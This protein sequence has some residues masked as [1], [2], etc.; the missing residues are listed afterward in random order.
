[1]LTAE[2]GEGISAFE[3]LFGILI[4]HPKVTVNDLVLHSGLRIPWQSAQSGH[5]V[6]LPTL[7]DGWQSWS[8]N[9]SGS[10][11]GAQAIRRRGS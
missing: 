10:D 11:Y 5:G 6:A 1:M 2:G 7:L 4:L 8:A 3:A 9:G